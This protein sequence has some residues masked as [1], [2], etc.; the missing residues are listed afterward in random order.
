M[1]YTN[2]K[3]GA[4]LHDVRKQ[5]PRITS[6]N[7]CYTKLLRSGVM[8]EK[9]KPAFTDELSDILNSMFPSD[10]IRLVIIGCKVLL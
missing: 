6:Y 2:L 7:V 1:P 3:M 4:L 10:S 5:K 8:R 9:S